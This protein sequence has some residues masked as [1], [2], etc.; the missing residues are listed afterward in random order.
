MFQQD[1]VGT[2]GCSAG[3]TL[4]YLGFELLGPRGCGTR[5]NSVLE[6][7]WGTRLQSIMPEPSLERLPASAGLCL[8]KE[9]LVL[10]V[11]RRGAK[12]RKS[13]KESSVEV[14]LMAV[15]FVT[16]LDIVSMCDQLNTAMA[17]LLQTRDCNEGRVWFKNGSHCLL[18]KLSVHNHHFHH[19]PPIT[20]KA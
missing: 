16:G 10:G 17:M 9:R 12:L 15:K 20:E 13:P 5:F 7:G 8:F 6:G 3:R 4:R 11:R 1:N 18:D 19:N 14:G 2:W